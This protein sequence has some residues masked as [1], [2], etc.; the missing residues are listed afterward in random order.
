MA[1]CFLRRNYD[2]NSIRAAPPA[3]SA[4]TRVFPRAAAEAKKAPPR[5]RRCGVHPECRGRLRQRP[6]QPRDVQRTAV[7]AYHLRAL[8]FTASSTRPVARTQ[9]V[10]LS[11]RPRHRRLRRGV[12]MG[13]TC[14]TPTSPKDALH[15]P[16][17]SRHRA[18]RAHGNLGTPGNQIVTCEAT[19]TATFK[20]KG[21][22]IN[23][24]VTLPFFT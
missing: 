13:R 24:P 11:G 16:G 19:A 5:N 22:E 2:L 4:P 6:A 20:N 12:A 18:E 3:D 1:V 9:W 23:V 15:R 10:P 8:S 21:V 17:S 7:I 14:S